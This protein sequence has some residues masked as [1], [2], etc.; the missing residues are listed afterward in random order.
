MMIY[1]Q[2]WAKY[3]V[4]FFELNHREEQ[5]QCLRRD[6]KKLEQQKQKL[7]RSKNGGFQFR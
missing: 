4:E 6:V 5:L 3:G 1:E 7:I 2:F